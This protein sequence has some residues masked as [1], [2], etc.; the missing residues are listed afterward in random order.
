MLNEIK[1]MINDILL[2]ESRPLI[3]DLKPN[4]SL[5]DDIGLD[6]LDLARL[7]VQIEDKY[8]VDIFKDEIVDKVEQIIQKINHNAILQ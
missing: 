1:N 7:T 3:D 8:G 6:S 5:R 2:S 4:L